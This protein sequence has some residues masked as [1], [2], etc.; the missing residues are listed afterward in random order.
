MDFDHLFKTATGHRPYE[1]QRRLACGDR[2]TQTVGDWLKAGTRCQTRLISVPTGLGKTAAVVLAWLWNRMGQTDPD[3]RKAWPRRLV[4]CL[5]MRTLV[6]QTQENA[7]RWIEDLAAKADEL[8]LSQEQQTDLRWLADHSPVILMG[9]EDL[10]EAKA[11]WDIYPEKPCILIGT[12]DM[13]LSRALNRGYGMSRY[14]WPMHF[15]LLNN[16][17]LWIMD[18]TQLMG[19]GV[20]TSAQ[21]DGFRASWSDNTPTWWMSATLDQTRLATVDHRAPNGGWPITTLKPMDLQCPEVHQRTSAVKPSR[22]AP[23]ALAGVSEKDLKDYVA[24]LTSMIEEQHQAGTLT[25]LVVNS[26]ARA[27]RVFDGLRKSGI[28]E[29]RL[30][31]VHSRFRRRDRDREQKRLIASR[32]L[33]CV[34]TQAVEAGL[35]VSARLLVTELAPWS[36]LV[37]RFGRCNRYGK[38]SDAEVI[39]VDVL[40][41]DDKQTAPYT[42]AELATARTVLEQLKDVGPASLGEK[43]VPA[44]P[45]V[46]PVLRRKDIL[47]L[48]DTTPDLAGQDLDISRYVRDGEDTDI[49]VFWREMQDDG[50]PDDTPEPSR[51]ELCRV[52]LPRFRDFLSKLAKAEPKRLAF[53]WSQLEDQWEPS[54]RAVGGATYLLPSFV[55]GYESRLGW[56]GQMADPKRRETWVQPMAV[57]CES[58]HA[59]AGNESS[60]IG[61]P[62]TLREHS[63]DVVG[64]V[65]RLGLRL[66]IDS[67]TLNVLLEAAR[68]HDV[69]KVNPHFQVLLHGNGPADSEPLAKSGLRHGG[70][71]PFPR[72][73]YRH[74]LASAFAWLAH[75]PTGAVPEPE[76]GDRDLV[77]YLIAAHHGKVRLSVR[78]LPGEEPPF[79]A[80]PDAR[81]A[82]GILDGDE[83]PPVELDGLSVPLTVLNLS[84]MEMGR[85]PEGPSWLA[86][87]LA[88]RDRLGPIQLAYLEALLRAADQRASASEAQAPV[89]P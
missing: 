52:S 2:G 69:G 47:E 23:F 53:V 78:A 15:G 30:A 86:R 14:R 59:Y 55:G 71:M 19:V 84:L 12:Q 51:E 64:E 17:C 3:H 25:L 73:F 36:S 65:Q 33:I 28:P 7:S 62:V 29:V 79:D 39:W 83:M 44:Q 63:R 57:E 34:A 88:L 21:L 42:V 72:Q 45:V 35:D 89:E 31:L 37:Q 4:Y 67:T 13:L 40:I 81:I 85:G 68:W 41:A 87:M 43:I 56:T 80:P 1:Y 24:K 38:Q 11:S 26:V 75:A 50:P 61:K 22:K 8:G 54:R 16:D 9:G 82:R 5:P 20:E 76:G 70:R 49:Q 74:E 77:A 46:R 18:E 32:D 60:L 6:E 58:A 66:N 10:D 48:F 27:Q